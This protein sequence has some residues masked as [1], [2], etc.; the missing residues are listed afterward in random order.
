MDVV[1]WSGLG[2]LTI[3]GLPKP[4][5]LRDSSLARPRI[6]APQ[7]WLALGYLLLVGCHSTVTQWPAPATFS[8][9]PYRQGA[10]R[11]ALSSEDQGAV[12]RTILQFYRPS[13]GHI[14]WL[15]RSLPAA[16]P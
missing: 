8:R 3:A 15:D 12:Y 4:R 7:T 6:T 1:T 2:I 16:T 11:L 10:E 5:H 14:R 13:R 9:S